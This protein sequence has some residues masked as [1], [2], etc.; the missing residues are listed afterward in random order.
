MFS[1]SFSRLID[2]LSRLPGIGP[3]SAQRIALH[4]VQRPVVEVESLADA[5]VQARHKARYCSIC[6]NL[7]EEDPCPI[8]RNPARDRSVVAVVEEVKDVMALERTH[9][10]NGVYHVLHGAIS[11]MEG[12]G[13]DHL[14]VG[15]LLA[16]VRGENPVPVK[17]VILAT[18]PD[19]EG[20]ATALYLA[21]LLAEYPVQVT[22][23]ARGLPVGADLDYADTVTLVRAL[24]GR[25]SVQE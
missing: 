2:E 15:Q 25:R 23:I 10:F 13:P 22:R 16:R 7:T 12:V 14:R 21:R 11:P 9:E 4:L 20:E 5:I 8:C 17:E 3:K 19:V 6:Q 18:D 24:Q 1:S